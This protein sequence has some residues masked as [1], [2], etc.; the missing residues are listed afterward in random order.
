MIC[1]DTSSVVALLE[2]AAGSDVELVRD[3]LLDGT[4]VLA[5]VSIAELLSDPDL[6]PVSEEALLDI[7]QL[8]ITLGYWERAGRLRAKLMRHRLRPKL[9]DSLIAQSCLD[10]QVPLITRDRDFSAFQKLAG[11]RL[12]IAEGRVQ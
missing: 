7:P 2:G 1:A 10:H 5:P 11:L 4:L 8:E 9:A 12:F 6:D 3:A